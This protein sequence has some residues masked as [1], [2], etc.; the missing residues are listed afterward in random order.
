[1]HNQKQA[2]EL[3][4]SCAYNARSSTSRDVAAELWR[5]AKEYQAEAAKLDDTQGVD[6]GEP[7]RSLRD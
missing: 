6:I 3:A 7:P 1:M 4:I 2:A 5:M